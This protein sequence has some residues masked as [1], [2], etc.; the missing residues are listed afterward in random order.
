MTEDLGLWQRHQVFAQHLV[1]SPESLHSHH[2]SLSHR[3]GLAQ[4]LALS[5]SGVSL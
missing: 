3:S 2:R 4:Y 1:L 5:Q